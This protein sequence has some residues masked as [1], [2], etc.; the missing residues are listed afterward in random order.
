MKSRSL[1]PRPQAAIRQL[2]ER[3]KAARKR[4]KWSQE[5]TASL[6]GLGVVAY[7]K[8][9]QGSPGTSVGAWAAALELMGMITDM[10]YPLRYDEDRLGKAIEDSLRAKRKHRTRNLNDLAESL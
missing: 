7:R 5:H 1:A 6:L 3:L 10:N 4:R 2:G 9:E 8:M